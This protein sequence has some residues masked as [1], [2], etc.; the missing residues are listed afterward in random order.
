MKVRFTWMILF[1]LAFGI[2]ALS[3]LYH[4]ENNYIYTAFIVQPVLAPYYL[5]LTFVGLR[6]RTDLFGKRKYFQYGVSM[7]VLITLSSIT[8]DYI[9]PFVGADFQPISLPLHFFSIILILIFAS[10]VQSAKESIDRKVEQQQYEYEKVQSSL[11]LLKRQL[12]PHF[13]FNTLHSIYLK[14]TEQSQDVPDMILNLSDMLRYQ[15]KMETTAEVTLQEDIEFLRH[16]I[17]FEKRRLPP[18][19]KVEFACEI[20]DSKL[21]IAPN[22]LTPV[23]E[24]TFKHGVVVPL[25]STI[26]I[27]IT[28]KRR[29]L[30]LQTSNNISEFKVSDSGTG[31]ANLRKRLA[32]FYPDKHELLLERK[33]DTCYA[34]LRIRL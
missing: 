5:G 29:T 30:L 4:V 1:L 19:M 7:L 22:M 28:L 32:Y 9:S 25:D 10:F 27:S 13:L 8:A 3:F 26:T 31:I 21:K 18:N 11:Q 15:L 20:S 16:Y 2:M 12:N 24:N 33:N 17:Y 34:T 23:V 14:A 6:L